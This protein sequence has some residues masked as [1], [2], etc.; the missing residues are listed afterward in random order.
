VQTSLK[1]DKER[2]DENRYLMIVFNIESFQQG[3]FSPPSEVVKNS[4]EKLGAH[5]KL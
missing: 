3:L 2:K 5:I 1:T 4:P